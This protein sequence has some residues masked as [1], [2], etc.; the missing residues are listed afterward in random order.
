MDCII[1]ADKF[2]PN[3]L[4]YSDIKKTLNGKKSLFINN[5]NSK[6]NLLQI[7]SLYCTFGIKDY[8]DSHKL[9]IELSLR[10]NSILNLFEKFD[11]KIINKGFKNSISWFSKKNISKDMLQEIYS[12]PIRYSVDNETSEKTRKYPPSL[13]VKIPFFK[14]KW[15]CKVYDE[16]RNKIETDLRDVIKPGC[17]IKATLKCNGLWFAN[18][19]FGCTWNAYKMIVKKPLDFSQYAF[20]DIDDDNL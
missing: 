10:D 14:G 19:K 16:N 5:L 17:E 18:G 6:S 2:N 13:K 12:S 11:K 20:I 8:E 3:I 15:Q 7:P 1:R 9:M 4:V